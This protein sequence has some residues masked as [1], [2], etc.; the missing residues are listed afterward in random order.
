[1]FPLLYVIGKRLVRLVTIIC[2]GFMILV[3]TLLGHASNFSIGA[4][5]SGARSS[6]LVEWIFFLVLF[7]FPIAVVIYKGV[8]FIRSTVRLGHVEKYPFLMACRRV[9][10]TGLNSVT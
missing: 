10:W 9:W 6:V 7:I 2:C 4:S 3:N 8:C 5:S 1:M